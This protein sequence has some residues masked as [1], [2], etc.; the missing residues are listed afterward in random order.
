METETWHCLEQESGLMK[1]NSAFITRIEDKEKNRT[2]WP[3]KQQPLFQT[4]SRIQQV[5]I[6]CCNSFSYVYIRERSLAWERTPAE[7]EQVRLE[8]SS[9]IFPW[10][11]NS[12]T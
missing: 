11:C 2:D 5:F 1:L 8:K 10:I 3:E 7:P 6:F 12:H 4:F 9:K